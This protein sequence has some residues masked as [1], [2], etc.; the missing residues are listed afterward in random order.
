MKQWTPLYFAACPTLGGTFVPKKM[1]LVW[2]RLGAQCGTQETAILYVI[3]PGVSRSD[4]FF[5]GNLSNFIVINF[6]SRI[7]ILSITKIKI[8]NITRMTQP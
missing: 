2:P 4:L 7:C 6:N 8:R 5:V 3:K 1:R